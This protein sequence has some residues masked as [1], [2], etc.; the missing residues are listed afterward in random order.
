MLVF[1]TLNVTTDLLLIVAGVI[2]TFPLLCF[3]AALTRLSLTSIGI[4]QYIAP[5]IGL[6]LAVAVYD[7]PFSAVDLSLF[8]LIW[9]GLGLFT[10][11]SYRRSVAYRRSISAASSGLD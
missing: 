5:S 7:E 11:D 6:I 2:I 3:A 8:M 4:L 1:G 9:L 10:F